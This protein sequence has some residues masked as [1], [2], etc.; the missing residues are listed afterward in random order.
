M[1]AIATVLAPSPASATFSI[2]ARDPATG[3]I[4]V[5][6][7]SHFFAVGRTVPWAEAGVGAV[8]TQAFAEASFGPRGLAL[9]RAGKSAKQAL[10]AL[11]AADPDRELRQLAIVDAHGEVAVHTGGQDIRFAGHR[12]GPGYGAQANMM[13]SPDVWPAMARAYEAARGP[14]AERMLA[15][16]DAAQGA[17]GDYRGKQSA[18]ILIVDGD[19]DDAPWNHVVLNLRV[20]DS[21]DPISELRRLYRVSRA[22][23][24][25]FEGNAL[26]KKKDRAGAL[27]A[28]AEVWQMPDATDE[29]RLSAAFVEAGVGELERA[30]AHART[31]LARSPQLRGNLLYMP[32]ARFPGLPAL[33]KRL[34]MA[35]PE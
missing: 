16:L 35:S 15:A 9:L 28:V 20:D 30:E 2:V 5:A 34:A 19:R 22:Y 29:V 26:A 33:R 3:Q 17:G 14:L 13:A 12:I 7:Q 8:A 4:G 24:R 6:V 31:V 1:L 23:A 27:A 18:A 32:V 21:P 25:A 11:L 10:D